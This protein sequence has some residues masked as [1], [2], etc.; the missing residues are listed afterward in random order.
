MV[1]GEKKVSDSNKKLLLFNHYDVVPPG[2]LENWRNPPFEP[3]VHTNRIWGR[4]VGDAKGQLIT[5]FKAIEAWHA[6]RGELPCSLAI[7]LNGDNEIGAPNFVRL[8]QR[9]AD[10]LRADAVFFADASTLDVWGPVIYLGNRG[11]LAIE[12]VAHGPAASV[13]SGSYGGL[14]KNPAIRLANALACLRD[15]NGQILVKGFH[16]DLEPLGTVQHRLLES[17]KLNRASKLQ[18]LGT[19]EFWGDPGHEYFET[20][21]FRPTLNVHGLTCG[22]QEKGWLAIVPSTAIAK[23]DINIVPNL[24]HDDIKQKIQ[25]QLIEQGFDDIEIRETGRSPY[26]TSARLDDPFLALAAR[27]LER[28]WGTAPVLYPSIGGGGGLVRILKEQIG[29]PHF[30]MVPFGQ[31][32]MN[33]H[34]PTESLDL[35]WF[36]RGIKAVVTVMDEFAKSDIGR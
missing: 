22:Y 27:A 2:P 21:M 9:Y 15:Q 32:D 13:H 4:G 25:R 5:Y 24:D 8:A 1:Y 7:A 19:S 10:K 17:L 11:V 34:S 35:D 29:N 30:L 28:V 33:E 26:A 23:I 20:Q 36:V 3:V 6:V 18:N 16:D 14:V 12:L 31:P